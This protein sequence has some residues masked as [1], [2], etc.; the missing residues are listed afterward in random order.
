MP[1]VKPEILVWARETAG[2]DRAD[3]AEALGLKSA[4]GQTGER[5]LAALEGG[6]VAPSTA[7]LTRMAKLYRRPLIA[8]YLPAPPRKGDRGEDFRRMPGSPAPDFDPNLDALIRSVRSRHDL[9]VSVL[10]DEEAPRRTFVGLANLSDSPEATAQSIRAVIGFNLSTFRQASDPG[11]AFS[12]LRNRLEAAGIFVLLIGDLGSHHSKIGAQTFRG[13]SLAHPIAPLV[14]INDNDARP[15]WSFTA[16]HET[17]HIWLGQ[18]GV[19]G[20]AHANRIEQYCNDVAGRL[21]IPTEDISLLDHLRGQSLE[22]VLA[23]VAPF[24][25][26]RNVSR[27]MVIYQLLR[28]RIIDDRL[29]SRLAA[30]LRA[31]FEASRIRE[32]RGEDEG[33]PNYYVVKRHRLGNALLSLAHRALQEGNLTPTKAAQLLAVKPVTVSSLL[34]RNPA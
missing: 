8:F 12:Y 17:V 25:D 1:A 21:L 34:D 4:R 5:R 20:G 6:T 18:S 11:A 9:L 16:L 3:A 29:Y 19:S 7:L 15:A 24:A 22:A 33:G 30:R 28:A 13:Y 31:D 14:V 23:A 32:P 10:E 2:F 26:D 27:A